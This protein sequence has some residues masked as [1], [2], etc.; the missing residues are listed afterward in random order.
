[1]EGQE[2]HKKC[3]S[4]SLLCCGYYWLGGAREKKDEAAAARGTT[5]APIRNVV[6]FYGYK[7]VC[8]SGYLSLERDLIFQQ[9]PFM[10]SI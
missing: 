1:V 4:L 10:A 8:L 3:K 9:Q 7:Y 6:I 5:H 2:I